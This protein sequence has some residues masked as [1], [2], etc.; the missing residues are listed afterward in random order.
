MFPSKLISSEE[1]ARFNCRPKQSRFI[2]ERS[3]IGHVVVTVQLKTNQEQ[4]M[5]GG[6]VGHEEA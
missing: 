1:I 4:T 6:C 5:G 3:A 2:A